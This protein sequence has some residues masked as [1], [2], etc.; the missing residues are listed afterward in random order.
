M[1]AKEGLFQKLC[2]V[3]MFCDTFG[4]TCDSSFHWEINF[5]GLFD[6]LLSAQVSFIWKFTAFSFCLNTQYYEISHPNL[7]LEQSHLVFPWIH[8][9]L[10]NLLS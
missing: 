7:T 5:K 10:M 4:Y 9:E 8:A 1:K 6:L 2:K 3:N